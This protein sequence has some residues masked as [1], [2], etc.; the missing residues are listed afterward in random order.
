M[1]FNLSS[2][3]FTEGG[4]IPKDYTCDG[5]DR[6]LPV[7]WSGIP[8]GTAELALIM[9]DPDA[10]GFVHWVVVGLPPTATGL[11][12]TS[13]PAGAREGRTGFGRAG[14]GG[15]CPP[16]G[17]HHYAITL[18]ALS[19]PLSVPQTPTADQ[20]RQAANGQTLA[21]ATLNG[22]YTRSR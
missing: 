13:L 12:G 19:A 21:K 22:T 7:A 5:A 3:A 15:P 20:V 10:R 17:T 18:Y 1:A 9:D 2:P 16:S 4:P 11:D 6:T 8:D 14:Y